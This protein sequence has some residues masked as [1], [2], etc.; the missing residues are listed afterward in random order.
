MKTLV[1][2]YWIK[3][4][5]FNFLTFQ[6]YFSNI[7]NDSNFFFLLMALDGF[8]C[9]YCDLIAHCISFFIFNPPYLK[10]FIG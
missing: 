1:S 5:A 2:V 6:N 4:N 10:I 8:F 3:N 9:N 7:S